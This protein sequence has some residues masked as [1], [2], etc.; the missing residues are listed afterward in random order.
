MS[1]LSDHSE[2]RSSGPA[3][4]F[5]RHSL[6]KSKKMQAGPRIFGPVISK[7]TQ[8]S[9]ACGG[10]IS[11]GSTRRIRDLTRGPWAQSFVRSSLRGP[12]EERLVKRIDT[13]PDRRKPRRPDEFEQ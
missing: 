10:R 1:F 3:D 12:G 2:F 11:P 9:G 8:R 6:L 7:S 5:S 4:L 13:R